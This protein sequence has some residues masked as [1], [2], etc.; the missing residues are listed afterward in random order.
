MVEDQQT[1]SR[2]NHPSARRLSMQSPDPDV[3]YQQAQDHFLAE[4]YRESIASLNRLRCNDRYSVRANSNIASCLMML[5]L[6][7]PALKYVDRALEL[8]PTYTPALINRVKAFQVQARYEEAMAICKEILERNP[9]AEEAWMNWAACLCANQQTELALAVVGQWLSACPDSLQGHLKQGELL[10]NQGDHSAAIQSLTTALR[11]APEA[12]KSYGHMSVVMYRMRRFEAALKYRDKALE[13]N[14]GS[15]SNHY[16]KAHI[17]WFIGYWRES[18]IHHRKAAAMRPDSAIYFLNQHLILPCIIESTE[19]IDEAREGFLQGLSLAENN[20][21]IHFNPNDQAEAHTFF[22]AYHNKEDRLL[23]ERYINLMRKLS[24]PLLN[25]YQ[26]QHHS[27]L[28]HHAPVKHDRL[29]IGFLSKYFS[30]HSNALAFGG[31]IRHLDRQNFH[32]I[33]IHTAESKRDAA[34]DNLDAACEGSIVL[35]S[36]Y[37]E[38]YKALHSLDLDILFFTDLGMNANEFLLPLFR[39]A[40]IQMTGWGIPHTS[41]IKEIDYYITSTELEPPE[42]Q[43]NYTET[44]IRLPGGLPCCFEKPGEKQY[45]A[46]PRDYFILPPGDTLVGCLQG[47]HKLHPDYDLIL[48]E[49]AIRNPEVGF[50]FVEDELTSRTQIFLDRLAKTTPSVRDRCVFLAIM[51]RHEYQALCN[52]V[53]LLLDPI[54]YGSGITFFE[55]SFVGTPIVTMEGNNLRT[56][57]VACGYREMGIDD[58]P[59]TKTKEEYIELVTTLINVPERRERMRAS[60]LA[61]NHRVFNRVDHIRS[62]EQFCLQA[63]QR[64]R[65]RDH[66]HPE[67]S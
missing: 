21:D 56:R 33:L 62:F 7:R 64:E 65:H 5:G 34:R 3:F 61:N 31:L 17:L 11:I 36:D 40:P 13:I 60:I 12:E 38:A 52:C 43:V 44:L 37:S 35:P 63:V 45:M 32:V 54:Y 50:V 25:H 51:Q 28:Q 58:P 41:G 42:A 20:P 49:I 67:A 47:L 14:P 4:Q 22:L 1:L 10:S 8:D 19:E 59:I 29:R 9:K 39:S 24:T 55:A 16:W 18:L 23:L 48:E 30:N 15:L 6:V 2:E 57:V 26:R 66:G 53:D 27:Q 46:L